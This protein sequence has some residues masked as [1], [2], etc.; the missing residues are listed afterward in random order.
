LATNIAALL[1]AVILLIVVVALLYSVFGKSLAA[2]TYTAAIQLTD[3]PTVPAGTQQLLVSYSS[4]QVHVSGSNST[5]GWV[6]A[7]GSGTI[8]LMAL[9][10]TS[11]TIAKA[12]VAANSTINIVR[13][14]ITSAKITINGTTYNVSSPNSRVTVSVTGAEKINSSSAVLVDFHPSVNVHGSGSATTYLLVPA[15]SAIVISS[16]STVSINT[17]IGSTEPISENI[18]AKLGVGVGAGIAAGVNASI[19]ATLPVSANATYGSTVSV[20]D[21]Q[22]IS[23]FMAQNISYASN[24]VSGLIYVQYPVA[25][26]LGSETTLHIGDT[27]G[28]ACDGTEAKLTEIYANNTAVFT[29]LTTSTRGGCPI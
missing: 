1:G 9:Q 15:A 21:G 19:N 4:V 3:P 20:Q 5:S 14:N 23:N 16:N 26:T 28:Y 2:G 11:Q 8:N 27:V 25:A 10:N 24:T 22:R 29:H 18:K 17:N 13:F 7:S 12:S 6:T